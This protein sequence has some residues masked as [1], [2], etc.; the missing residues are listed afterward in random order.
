MYA[1]AAQNWKPGSIL[2]SGFVNRQLPFGYIIRQNPN[3][4]F[5][6]YMENPSLFRDAMT[7][8]A[9]FAFPLAGMGFFVAGPF[10]VAAGHILGATIGWV[11]HQRIAGKGLLDIQSGLQG[12]ILGR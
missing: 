3:L 8:E 1:M 7:R 10:G 6:Y 5:Q 9:G 11:R 4:T 2:F 12:G